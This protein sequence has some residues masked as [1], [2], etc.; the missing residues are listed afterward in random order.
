[1]KS[2]KILSLLLAVVMIASACLMSGCSKAT[3]SDEN[4]ANSTSTRKIT[5]LNMYII[6]EDTT[7]KEA[8]NKVQMEI[9]R[10]LL[11]EYKTMLKINYITQ[12]E[13]WDTV[14]EML[15]KTDP[16]NFI[17][18]KG[19][20]VGDLSNAEVVGTQNLSFNNLIDFIFDESTTD[21]ELTKDQIDI[22]VV[23]DYDKYCELANDGKLASLNTYLDYDSKVLK[24]YIYPTLMSVAKVGSDTFGIPTNL[25]VES[26]EY[27]YFVF[28]KDLLDKY[29][30]QVKDLRGYSSVKFAEYLAKIKANEAGIWP[31]SGTCDIAGAEYYDGA[32]ISISPQFNKISESCNPMF[33]E[34]AYIS[35]IK[36]IKNYEELGYYPKTP[37]DNAKY[38]IKIEKSNELIAEKEWTD[39]TGTTYVRY[40]Y[41][42]PRLTA[43]DAF[44]SAMCVSATSPVPDR[45]MEVITLFNTDTELANL[46]QYGIEGENYIY[47][48]VDDT[49]TVLDDTYAMDNVI[50]G[51]TYIKYPENND[52]KYVENSIKMNLSAAPSAYIGFNPK[53]ETNSE[54]SQF[55]CVKTV[56]EKGQEAVLAGAD[57]DEISAI[58]SREL[59]LLGYG[60][61]STTELGGIF[62]KIQK[63]H[64]SQSALISQSFKIS[65]EIIK[66]NEPYGVFIVSQA[67]NNGAK[68]ED[69]Q[70]DET[71]EAD[72]ELTQDAQTDGVLPEEDAAVEDAAVEDNAVEEASDVNE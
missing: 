72:E 35:H 31:V 24:S 49:I 25:G 15:E 21:I 53:F 32:F 38:A 9:N 5:A 13:Y 16:E 56:L 46:L 41:D 48:K 60:Y 23:N 6:T 14:E 8:A 70:T 39:S 28:N 64:A 34:S 1:M 42:I 19:K 62:G 10:I 59:V 40:L 27:T 4:A 63:A 45:A 57:M 50:T 61:V 54:I 67:G 2:T 51:N 26:G 7:T 22:F 66:Y 11:P 43:Y 36:A 52:K 20:Y 37:I 69:V 44:T 71:K 29:G 33:M 18:A 55:E 68:N 47:N 3:N 65:E 17:D 12:D 58:V 30:Y